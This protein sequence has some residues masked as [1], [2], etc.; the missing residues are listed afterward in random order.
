MLEEDAG[1]ITENN[2]EDTPTGR[3]KRSRERGKDNKPRN[4]P[5]H[6]MKKLASV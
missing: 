1:L 6:T 2:N 3:R 4:F 5:L